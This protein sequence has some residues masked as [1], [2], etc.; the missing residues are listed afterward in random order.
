MFQRCLVEFFGNGRH[1]QICLSVGSWK[2]YIIM[3]IG[4]HDSMI[5]IIKNGGQCLYYYIFSKTKYSFCELSVIRVSKIFTN[6]G[7]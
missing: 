7:Y 5:T 4:A 6:K 2:I 3:V 1:M